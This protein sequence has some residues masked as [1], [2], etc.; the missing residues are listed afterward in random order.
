MVSEPLNRIPSSDAIVE[1]RVTPLS[2]RICV[3]VVT[4]IT[5]HQQVHERTREQK[6]V[7]KRSD[8]VRAMV[9]DEE[10][11]QYCE[12]RVGQR[13]GEPGEARARDSVVN[14]FHALLGKQAASR[15]RYDRAGSATRHAECLTGEHERRK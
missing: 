3:V 5:M 9:S 10:H 15:F 7:R 11:G 6:Q 2:R 14:G 13:P 1:P 4:V 8:D 12:G